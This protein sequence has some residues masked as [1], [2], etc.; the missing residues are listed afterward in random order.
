MIFFYKK[1]PST[2][3]YICMSC[4][5]LL[6]MRSLYLV[7]ALQWPFVN[8]LHYFPVLEHCSVWPKFRLFDLL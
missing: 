5:I 1:K 3:V 8:L 6:L 4:K 2:Q 7:Q